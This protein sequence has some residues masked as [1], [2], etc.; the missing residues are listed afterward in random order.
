[1]AYPKTETGQ[2]GGKTPTQL[3]QKNA[4]HDYQIRYSTPGHRGYCVSAYSKITY[5]FT[6]KSSDQL[7]LVMF[8]SGGVS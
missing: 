2:C 6:P 5:F 1:M 3:L 8:L 4:Q 7:Q